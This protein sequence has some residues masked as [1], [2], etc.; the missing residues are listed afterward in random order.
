MRRRDL[1]DAMLREGE[2][3]AGFEFGGFRRAVLERLDRMGREKG[4]DSA[5]TLTA[6]RFTEEIDM[7]CLDL[8]GWPAL[9]YQQ[10]FVRQVWTDDE[11]ARELLVLLAMLGAQ[12]RC[13]TQMLRELCDG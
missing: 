6:D 5:L 7:E 10:T 11:R 1:E 13:V 4:E 12:G 2:R 3:R 9:A 8:G